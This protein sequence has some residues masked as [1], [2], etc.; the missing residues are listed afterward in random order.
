MTSSL[1]VRL[2]A[3]CLLSTVLAVSPAPAAEGDTLLPGDTDVILT[4]NVRRIL[5]DHEKTEDVRRYLEPWRLALRGDEKELK[6]YYRDRDVRNTEGITEEQFLNRARRFKEF[7]DALGMDVLRDVDRV[8][9]GFKVGDAGSVVVLV[10]GRFKEEKFRAAVAPLAKEYVGSSRMARVGPVEVWQVP[11]EADGT[12]LVLLNEKVLL[13]A[14]GKNGMDAV[15]ARAAGKKDGGLPAATQTLLD[16]AAKEHFALVVNNLD[17]ALKKAGKLLEDEVVKALA[18]TETV[19]NIITKVGA[20]AREHGTDYASAALGLSVGEDEMRLKFGVQTKKPET[21][22][23]VRT[24]VGRVSV[25]GALA[26]KAAGTD[27]SRQLADI[28]VRARLSGKDSLVVVE[29]EVPHEFSSQALDAALTAFSGPAE[30]WVRRVTSIRLWGPLRPPPRGSLEVEEVLDVA[31]R[32]DPQAD[33]IRHR[34][35]LFVPRGKKDFPVVVLVHGGAWFMGDNRCCG[36]YTS[37]G[38]FLASQ[39]IGVV[40]PNYRLSPV[41]RHPAHVQDVAKAVAWTRGHIARYGGNPER[42]YLAGHSAGGHLVSLLATDES[43]LKAEGLSAA[44]VK[45]VIAVSGVYRIRPGDVEVTLGGSGPRA[46]RPE[47]F[48]PLRGDGGP[49]FDWTVPGIPYRTDVFGAAFGDSPKVRAA[50]SPVTHVRRGLPPF[51]IL[52]ASDDLPSQQETADEFHKALVGVGCKSQF[53]KVP[54]RNHNSLIFSVIRPDDPVARA[55]LEFLR[56]PEKE[57]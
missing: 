42:L 15:L 44:D 17:S 1:S 48:F 45:G 8:T 37:V 13:I 34:L 30:P 43:Y 49:L 22:E 54:K 27:L 3:A 28:L 19:K 18:P 10:E 26:L 21:A 39:G 7:N 2:A 35:D 52:T 4:L 23:D 25:W 51:L 38:Q 40:L 33:P 6:A 24:A 14:R 46:V 41:V 56:Q 5:D 16:G 50:A 47:V 20:W 55:I 57:K 31:Y 12:R 11:A 32:D 36:L 9:C 53:T 29:A